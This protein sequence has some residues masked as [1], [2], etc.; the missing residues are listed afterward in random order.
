MGAAGEAPD[1]V[2]SEIISRRHEVDALRFDLE[3]AKL[4]REIAD[5][6]REPP[7]AGASRSPLEDLRHE[8]EAAQLGHEMAKLTQPVPEDIRRAEH[9]VR[10]A[11]LTKEASDLKP[12]PV[13][14]WWHSWGSVA[15][16]TAIISAM[17]PT[18]SAVISYFSNQLTVNL[19]REKNRHDIDLK[20]QQQRHQIETEKINQLDQIGRAYL[21]LSQD[22]KQRARVLRFAK[23]TAPSPEIRQWAAEELVVVQVEI[24]QLLPHR[25][26]KWE[27]DHLTGELP[28]SL[29]RQHCEARADKEM[30][31]K[32]D[33]N[34]HYYAKGP[35]G[36]WQEAGQVSLHTAN[37]KCVESRPEAPVSTSQTQQ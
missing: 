10:L 8:L 22:P 9:A 36:N 35:D 18:T 34:G 32:G 29:A 14:R 26:L 31:R 6:Q 20:D 5:L 17:V 3:A 24:D 27:F 12:V 2:P 28:P 15:G 16:V 19:E 13:A 30:G 37:C 11:T 4:K 25:C 33:V 21:T 7:M 23:S 1:P